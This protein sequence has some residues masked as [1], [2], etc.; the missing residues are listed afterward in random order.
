MNKAVFLDRDGT[1]NEE[2]DYLKRVEDLKV[3][4]YT[5]E[6]LE[7]LKELGF[8]NIIITNQ[9]GVARG[10]FTEEDLKLI[11]EELLGITNKKTKLIDDIYYSPFHT[12]GTIEKYKIESDLRKPRIGMLLKARKEHSID[13]NSSFFIGDTYTDMKTA[14]NA[15][16]KKILVL[17][18]YGAEH[19]Q[20]CL[21]ENLQIDFIAKDLLDAANHI[22]NLSN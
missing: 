8:L 5:T 19:L 18:G 13:L 17:T 6:A 1:I 9:S 14:Q 20:K 7:I 3:Y 12:E 15:G 11:H 2:V 4:S 10:F 21:D 22:K 16:L